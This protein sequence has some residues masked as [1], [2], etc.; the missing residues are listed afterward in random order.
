MWHVLQVLENWFSSLSEYLT[1]ENHLKV[2]GVIVSVLTLWVAFQNMKENRFKRRA[3]EEEKRKAEQELD[4]AVRDQVVERRLQE[5]KLQLANDVLSIRW[6]LS[7][8]YERTFL[9]FL[10]LYGVLGLYMKY[11]LDRI[12]AANATASA[13]ST[14]AQAA[15]ELATP[16]PRSSSEASVESGKAKSK[17]RLPSPTKEVPHSIEPSQPN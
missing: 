6:T 14:K 13:A 1:Q 3:A 7:R 16:K 2:I 5:L 8:K 9:L 15:I 10:V 11:S 17:G 4:E 12:K